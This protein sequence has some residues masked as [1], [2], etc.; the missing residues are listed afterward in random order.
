MRDQREN[1]MA[2]ILLLE[3]DILLAS[4]L[5]RYFGQAKHKVFAYGDPQAAITQ[6]DK[7]HPDIVITEL[8]LA[9]RS[10]L[11]FLYEF[12][13]Y[14][15]WQ[16]VPVIVLSNLHNR[17]VAAYASA[18]EELDIS[19]YLYK[20]ATKLKQVLDSVEHSLKPIRL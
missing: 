3:P 8:Q 12:R 19:C 9:G 5:K 13:S 17:A 15:E 20:P 10:G 16:A 2:N 1:L 18:F 11:E 7:Q 6:A 14:P 4:N